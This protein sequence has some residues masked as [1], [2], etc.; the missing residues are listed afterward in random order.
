LQKKIG[1]LIIARNS[2]NPNKETI[3]I[4]LNISHSSATSLLTLVFLKILY[5]IS[6]VIAVIP[7]NTIVKNG[8]VIPKIH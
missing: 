1:V 6:L 5:G 2:Y 7:Y 8:R 4:L 3:L